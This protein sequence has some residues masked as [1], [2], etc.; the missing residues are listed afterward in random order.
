[1]IQATVDR[2]HSQHAAEAEQE[3]SVATHPQSPVVLEES[4]SHTASAEHLCT[5]Q[6][7]EVEVCKTSAKEEM[8]ASE[9]TVEVVMV[10]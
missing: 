3:P 4:G 9:V 5:M 1:M 8:L 6:V 10:E 2:E 7:A